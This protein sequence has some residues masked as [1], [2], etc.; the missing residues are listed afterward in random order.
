ANTIKVN[1]FTLQPQVPNI[2]LVGAGN[3]TRSIVLPSLKKNKAVIKSISSSMGL[4]AKILAKKYNIAYST[5]DNNIILTDE[6][7]NAIV[8]TTPHNTH[9]GIV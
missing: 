9:A 7:I 4:N 6:D 1:D 2:G 3:F 5:T 8:V